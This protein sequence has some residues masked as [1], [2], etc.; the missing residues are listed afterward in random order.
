MRKKEGDII[1]QRNSAPEKSMNKYS[2]EVL[3]KFRSR[4]SPIQDLLRLKWKKTSQ[5]IR[6][7]SVRPL[8]FCPRIEIAAPWATEEP[9]WEV[10]MLTSILRGIALEGRGGQEVERDVVLLGQ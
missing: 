4:S 7:G 3:N 5:S 2:L 10:L 9:A 1:L 8:C 6:M